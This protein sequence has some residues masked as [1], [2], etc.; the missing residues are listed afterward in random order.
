MIRFR[1]LHLA[2]APPR[3][4]GV[5]RRRKTGRGVLRGVVEVAEGGCG[6]AMRGGCGCSVVMRAQVV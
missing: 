6:F 2:G 3:L 5:V 4:S 1:D